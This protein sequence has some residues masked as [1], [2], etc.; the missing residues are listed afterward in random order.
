[1]STPRPSRFPIFDT[2]IP[3]VWVLSL[4][5]TVIGTIG[6]WGW[7][8]NNTMH[9]AMGT[10]GSVKIQIDNMAAN[11]ADV[12]A[13]VMNLTSKVDTL[14]DKVQTVQHSADVQGMQLDLLE[15]GQRV[16]VQDL[17]KINM[18]E[19]KTDALAAQQRTKSVSERD[20]SRLTADQIAPS[21]DAMY[22]HH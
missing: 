13:H 21:Y 5:C 16:R 20:T 7:T 18:L 17:A 6:G 14:T 19:K 11:N 9:D 22:N 8:I 12:K 1:M 15:R 4:A 2:R 3:I 10:M